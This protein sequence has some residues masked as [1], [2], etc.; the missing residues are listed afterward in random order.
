[1]PEAAAR[2]PV[3]F[4]G[5]GSP[6]N[7]LADNR[8]T[9]AWRRLGATLPRPKAVLVVSAHWY[10]A[11]T[12]VTVMARPKTIHDFFGF[13]PELFAYSYPAP[14]DPALAMRVQELLGAAGVGLDDSWGLDHGAWSVLAHLFPTASV[15]VIELSMDRSKPAAFH[16]ELGRKLSSL[17]DEGVLILA[18]GNVVHNLRVMRRREDAPA[19]EWATEF[20]DALRECLLKGDHT[21]VTNP[22]SLGDSA[23]MSIPSPDHYL[24]L[25]YAVGAQGADDK[26]E[27]LVDGIDLA[28]ISMLSIVIG[29]SA[30]AHPAH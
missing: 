15:P 19:F 28:S 25:L 6:M 11:E 20:N 1:M 24:P 29:G 7:A 13:P 27:V 12:A 14:G 18:S 5:H 9:Q 26:V 17:R 3:V 10:V 21:A 22:I 8:Y 16:Y 30:P 4:I 2:L 23:R